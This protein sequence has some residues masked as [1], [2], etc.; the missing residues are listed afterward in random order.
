VIFWFSQS[1]LAVSAVASQKDEGK[2]TQLFLGGGGVLAAIGVQL[3]YGVKPRLHVKIAYFTCTTSNRRETVLPFNRAA[4]NSNTFRP[5]KREVHTA[6][7][8]V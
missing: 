3:S 6:S 1:V 5:Q 4:V 8:K 7:Y 2:Q